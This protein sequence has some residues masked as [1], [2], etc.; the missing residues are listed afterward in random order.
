MKYSYWNII[1]RSKGTENYAPEC[2]KK[3]TEVKNTKNSSKH[4]IKVQ[5]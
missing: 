2:I 5:L 3:V 4:Y 1:R